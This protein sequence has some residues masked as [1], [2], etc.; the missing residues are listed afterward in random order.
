MFFGF[1]CERK[2]E[3]KMVQKEEPK[4]CEVA[5]MKVSRVIKKNDVGVQLLNEENE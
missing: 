5:E 4:V 3:K 2:Q 1:V